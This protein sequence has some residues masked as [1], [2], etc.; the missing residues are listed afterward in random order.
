MS[1]PVQQ[2]TTPVQPSPL[3]V[4]EHRRLWGCVVL[5]V[6]VLV[7]AVLAGAWAGW[8]IGSL[9]AIGATRGPG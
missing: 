4:N 7:G 9:P 1:E 3:V 5:A 6:A 2:T 8:L